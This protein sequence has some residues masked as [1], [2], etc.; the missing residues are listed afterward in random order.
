ME[1]LKGF[2]NRRVVQPIQQ[3]VASGITPSNLA[4]ALVVGLVGGLFP[5]PG[6]TTVVVFALVFVLRVNMIAAQVVNLL[7]TPLQVALMIPQ[8]RLGQTLFAFFGFSDAPPEGILGLLFGSVGRAIVA[9]MLLAVPVGLVLFL[10]VTPIL[11]R[12]FALRHSQRKNG[13]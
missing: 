12:L 3:V 2:I 9:W 1:W 8:M 5:V 13:E 4:A 11:A 10:I 7:A 6:V